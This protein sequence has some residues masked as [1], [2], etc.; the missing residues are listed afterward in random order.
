[1]GRAA[2]ALARS[3]AWEQG[4]ILVGLLLLFVF[5]F[6]GGWIQVSFTCPSGDVYCTSNSASVDTLWNGFGILPAL[7]VVV[8]I[9]WFVVTEIPQVRLVSPAHR[10]A[11]WQE[12]W[13]AF[14]AGEIVLFVMDWLIEGSGYTG[15]SSAPGWP[16]IT[17]VVFAAVVGIGGYLERQRAL[18][19]AAGAGEPSGT[20]TATPGVEVEVEAEPVPAPVQVVAEGTLSPD[21]SAWFD[22][23]TWQDASLSPPP[24]ALRSPDGSHWWDGETWRPVPRWGL[25]IQGERVRPHPVA[26]EA[27]D[28]PEAPH[29]LGATSP[30]RSAPPPYRPP[31][32]AQRPPGGR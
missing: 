14:A 30:P 11:V 23:T 5:S 1:M 21:R 18:R 22:G 17:S 7:V 26:S 24:D 6:V 9:V 3:I 29:L 25:R 27:G 12:T 28:Q 15:Y 32:P 2:V 19:V 16:L 10:A 8:A 13:V 20:A 4:L 31:R